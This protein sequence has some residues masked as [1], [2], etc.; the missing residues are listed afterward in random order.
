M[1][2]TPRLG[3][4]SRPFQA[5]TGAL[6]LLGGGAGGAEPALPPLLA[7][8]RSATPQ[9]YAFAVGEQA[10]FLPT[11][12]G[13]SHYVLR[14][15]TAKAGA[16]PAPLVV[17]LH[18]HGSWA[19]DEFALWQPHLRDR[20][21]GI[22]AL[23]W[24]FGQGERPQDYY[25]PHEIFRMVDTILRDLK[26]APRTVLLHGFSRGSAN[27]YGVM[28]LDHD[29]GRRYALLAVAN[30]GKPGEDFPANLEITRGRFGA[31]P[32][33]GTHWVTYAGAHD[34][35]PDRDG[36]AG[37]REAGAFIRRF[38]GTVDLAIEDAEGD[39]GGFHRRT[40]NVRAA[41]DLYQRLL[42]ETTTTTAGRP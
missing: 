35:H 39:H 14:L 16:P 42:T 41:L 13:R 24:W 7:E 27:L 33:A 23:Q 20:G 21:M 1:K 31:E 10:T 26:T 9:R 30:A 29:S 22:L 19:L 37:M 3:W 18:G 32:F 4:L 36:L 34:A 12:D 17:T 2:C 5:A 6:L 28:A 8:A 15:P 38:G 25:Q 40:Q 11:P